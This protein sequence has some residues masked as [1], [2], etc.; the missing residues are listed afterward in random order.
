MRKSRLSKYAERKTRKTILLNL[1]GIII[2]LYLLFKFGIGLL[3]NFSLFLSGSKDQ[4]SLTGQNTLNYISPPTLNP[5]PT[6]TNSA[7]IKISGNSFKDSTVELYINN[8]KKSEIQANKKDEYSFNNTLKTGNNQ[9]KVRTV[10]KDRKSDFSN[11]HNVFYTNSAPNLEINSPQDGQQFKK[12]QN[13]INVTG[14]TDS[15]VNVTVNG[16]WAVINEA[17]NFSYNLSLQNG[18]NE[19]K[20]IAID[21]AGNKT[22]KAIKVNYSP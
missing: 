4:Q 3:I 10:F 5:L 12:D 20:V 18:D 15:G 13:T 16:F 14:K 6:A 8:D 21:Q 9:I 1:L 11:T 17:N 22:E 19:I 2:V 7:Q